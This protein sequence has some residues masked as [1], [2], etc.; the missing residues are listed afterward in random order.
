MISIPTASGGSEVYTSQSE[1]CV[2]ILIGYISIVLLWC[3]VCPD[4]DFG[5]N[6]IYEEFYRKN[7][8]EMILTDI[9]C[10]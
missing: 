10:K 1:D 9:K 3:T 6:I 2:V 8:I 5:E 4:F 7:Y